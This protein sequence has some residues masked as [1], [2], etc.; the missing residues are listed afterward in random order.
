MNRLKGLYLEEVE[1]ILDNLNS[2]EKLEVV[3]Q[4]GKPQLFSINF[5]NTEI[6]R[7][8]DDLLSFV[9]KD[10]GEKDLDDS[11][12]RYYVNEDEDEDDY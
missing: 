3:R 9:E 6:Y 5:E 10:Y 4:K 2:E 11:K 8:M 7:R 12:A 1:M